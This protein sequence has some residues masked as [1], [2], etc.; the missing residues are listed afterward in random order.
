MIREKLNLNIFFIPNT[1]FILAVVLQKNLYKRGREPETFTIFLSLEMSKNFT[2]LSFY[3]N[4]NTERFR[5]IYLPKTHFN[6]QK[7][8]RLK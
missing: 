8:S 3:E 2:M 5:D 1:Y 6:I 4:A 7:N